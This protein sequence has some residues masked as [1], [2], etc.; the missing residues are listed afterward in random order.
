M[1]R[2]EANNV[3]W[4]LGP[5]TKPGE[6]VK[7]AVEQQAELLKKLSDTFGEDSTEFHSYVEQQRSMAETVRHSEVFKVAGLPGGGD[8]ASAEARLDAKARQMT[9]QDPGMTLEKA[10]VAALE[11]NPDLYAEYE[12]ERLRRIKSAD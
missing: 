3:R 5:L 1:G 2:S 11:R 12:K 10:R 6:D 7:S 8:P 9:E 4:W